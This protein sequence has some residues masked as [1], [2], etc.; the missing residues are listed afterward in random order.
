MFRRSFLAAI[1]SDK[2]DT[3]NNVYCIIWIMKLQIVNN[4]FFKILTKLTNQNTSH[5]SKNY[6]NTTYQLHVGQEIF[7]SYQLLLLLLLLILL[8]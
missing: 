3:I 1:H 2:F 6:E 5:H 4:V 7:S 8:F